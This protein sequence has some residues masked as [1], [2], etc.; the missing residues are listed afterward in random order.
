MTA[1]AK[2]SDLEKRWRKLTTAET[3]RADALLSDAALIIEDECEAAGVNIEYPDART[4]EKLSVISCEMVKRAMLAGTD[5]APATQGSL[6]VGP[7]SQSVTYA[8]PTGALYMTKAEKR[9]IG[10]GRQ[11]MGFIHPWGDA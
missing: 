4:K 10:I 7:F 9:R 5:A 11:R 1:Y 8:N 6:T 3:E 2:S